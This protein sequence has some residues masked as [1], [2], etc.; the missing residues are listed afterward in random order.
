[1]FKLLMAIATLSGN[2]QRYSMCK[3]GCNIK[4]PDSG[5]IIRKATHGQGMRAI[6][7]CVKGEEIVYCGKQ[8][9]SGD[10]ELTYIV[11]PDIVFVW[12]A[13]QR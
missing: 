12:T 7:S 13:E 6:V 4:I 1:M 10:V 3:E 11:R 9:P 2:T 5:S 8:I